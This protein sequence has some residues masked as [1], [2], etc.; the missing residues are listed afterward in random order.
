M[1]GENCREVRC[2][3]CTWRSRVG[4]GCRADETAI[5]VRWFLK[6]A[7]IRSGC[8]SW[9]MEEVNSPEICRLLEKFKHKHRNAVD[10]GRLRVRPAG[11]AADARAPH[12]GH[13]GAPGAPTAAAQ[14]R[15]PARRVQR[16]QG[17]AR[18]AR[19]RHRRIQVDPRRVSTSPANPRTST[20]RAGSTSERG[21]S[22]SRRTHSARASLRTGS[23]GSAARRRTRA[24]GSPRRDVRGRVRL[25]RSGID[26]CGI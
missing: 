23:P 1:I 25:Y 2:A 6:E 9:S 13:A 11:G 14:L 5:G 17:A 8:T 10:W 18:H 21:P 20:R 7:V 24:R 3:A 15:A 16:D 19:A 22:A 12:R 26:S 4:K